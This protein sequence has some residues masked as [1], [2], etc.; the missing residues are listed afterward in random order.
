MAFARADTPLKDGKG[1][2][3][4]A[5]ELRVPSPQLR[6]QERLLSSGGGWLFFFRSNVDESADLVSGANLEIT[7]NTLAV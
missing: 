3:I 2:D 6:A 7:S 1:A 5:A 4:V